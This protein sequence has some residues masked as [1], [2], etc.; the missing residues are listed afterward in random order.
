MF[1]YWILFTIPAW[2][3]INSTHTRVLS[4]IKWS[5]LWLLFFLFIVLMIGFRHDV[6][7]DWG[8]YLDKIN[9]TARYSL[10]QVISNSE[11]GYA[12]LNFLTAGTG[13]GIYLVNTACALIFAWGLIEFSRNQPRPWLAITVAI[14]YLVIVV[15]MGYTRQGTAIGFCML[16]M[17]ALFN[18]KIM[19]FIVFV[20]LAAT[21]HKSAVILVPLAALA[22][23]RNKLWTI[24]WVL[25]LSLLVYYLYEDAIVD[26]YKYRYIDREAQS[27]GAVIRCLM[28]VVPAILF[29]F[30]RGR[31][32]RIVVFKKEVVFW[33]FISLLA[34]VL[35]CLLPLSFSSTA[36]DRF[37]LY[38]IPLQ[39]FVFSR[40]PE[41]FGNA[42][43]GNH[44]LVLAV[45][46]YSALVQ[47]VWLLFALHAGAW[48]PYQFYPWVWLT[49]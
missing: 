24:S 11:A 33:T 35:F 2:L 31:F 18:G 42:K 48:L 27:S 7:G 29:L 9:D 43:G 15:A 49:Q 6:G 5:Q 8:N 3:A 1:P 22:A 13:F 16:G 23:D 20:L 46:L 26:T 21:F 19:R 37:G 14:P 47:L 25:L 44:S 28:N 12:L 38:L 34:I 4:S 45:V 17:V 40:F 30:L 10:Q 39:L 32:N 36:I 41:A